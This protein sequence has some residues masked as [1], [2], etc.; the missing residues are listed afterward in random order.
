[1]LP[2][3]G[4]GSQGAA[5]PI[6]FFSIRNIDDLD[7]N[8]LVRQ[9]GGAWKP[10]SVR[11]QYVMAILQSYEMLQRYGI[12]NPS[13]LA[14]FIGQ[15][16]VETGGL[17]KTIENLNYSAERLRQVWPSR[18]RTDEIAREYARQP[19]RIANFVYSSRLGNGPPESGDGWTYRGRG[20]FQLTGRSNYR[21]FGQIAGFDLENNPRAIEDVKKSIEVAAAYFQNRDLGRY[22]DADDASAVSRGVNLGDPNSS[23]P[24]HGE[25]ERVLW[26]NRALDLVRDPQKLVA[27][28]SNDPTLRIGASG[29]RVR[30]LQRDLTDLGYPVGTI[31]GVFGPATRRAVV[32]F[33]E[34]R[35]LPT[36]GVVDE[37]TRAALDAEF[38]PIVVNTPSAPTPIEPTPAPVLAPAPEAAPTPI[39][40]HDP[41]LAP[42]VEA[43]PAASEPAPAP[44]VVAEPTPAPKAPVETPPAPAPE[45]EASEGSTPPEAAAPEPETPPPDQ[46]STPPQPQA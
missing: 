19:E 46:P 37:A 39:L 30:A 38:A 26:T 35:R 2:G 20:F 18:F 6:S 31:D 11:G 41:E 24:A 16:I 21:T 43:P 17:T 29:E 23:T 7:F 34:E 28:A 4:Q 9:L 13:R 36:T 40:A 32:N 1:M 44:E 5:M 15:G 10:F 12:N 8:A 27:R 3:Q 14:H 45:P 22:A 33:Q 25:A 42:V